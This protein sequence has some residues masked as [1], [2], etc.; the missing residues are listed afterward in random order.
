MMEGEFVM[1]LIKEI[2]EN[3]RMEIRPNSRGLEYLEGVIRKNDLEL[4]KSLLAKH[5]G[6][7]AKEPETE[8]NFPKEIQ[9]LVDSIGGLRI[10]QSFFYR[11]EANNKVLYAAL[12]PWES[13]TEKTTLKAGVGSLEN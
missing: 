10:E 2:L 12:W 3:L 1:T 6:P 13:D 8:V 11:Q 7:A 9:R 5:L 4:L